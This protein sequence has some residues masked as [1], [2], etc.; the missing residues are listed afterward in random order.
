M[1][2]SKSS[3]EEADSDDDDKDPEDAG[4]EQHHESEGEDD[5]VF[6]PSLMVGNPGKSRRSGVF[7]DSGMFRRCELKAQHS[8]SGVVSSAGPPLQAVQSLLY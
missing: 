5:F 2:D 1:F 7:P 4:S 3:A 6:E 8:S